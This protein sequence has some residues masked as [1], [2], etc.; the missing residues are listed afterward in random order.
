M[1]IPQAA[2]PILIHEI[3]NGLNTPGAAQEWADVVKLFQRLSMDKQIRLAVRITNILELSNS[4]HVSKRR[5]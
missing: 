4:L 3:L 5:L 2:A 1:T